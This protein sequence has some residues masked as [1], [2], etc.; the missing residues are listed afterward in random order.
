MSPRLTVTCYTEP[1]PAWGILACI[2]LSVF[3]SHGFGVLFTR[4]KW[5]CSEIP[6]FFLF[7]L[8]AQGL[9]CTEGQRLE[10]RNIQREMDPPPTVVRKEKKAVWEVS[11]A[12]RRSSVSEWV[13]HAPQ[14]IMILERGFSDFSDFPL[15]LCF[16]F[17]YHVPPSA[18]C[19]V[20]WHRHVLSPFSV[21][22]THTQAPRQPVGLIAT[23]S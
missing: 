23:F 2:R 20:K 8:P 11:T 16:K 18:Y 9:S 5:N 22:E 21:K 19:A 7:F 17:D 12:S 1:A 4:S 6:D 10:V 14:L 3:V 13:M 15:S